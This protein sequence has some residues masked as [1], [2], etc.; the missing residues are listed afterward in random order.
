[1]QPMCWYEIGGRQVS[2]IADPRITDA[3]LLA[4]QA[5]PLLGG[6]MRVEE[7]YFTAFLRRVRLSV[8]LCCGVSRVQG[9]AAHAAPMQ[10]K[11]GLVACMRGCAIIHR[12]PR[13]SH[14]LLAGAAAVG[15]GACESPVGIPEAARAR[16]RTM[17]LARGDGRR[18]DG[19]VPPDGRGGLGEDRLAGPH[20]YRV[21]AGGRQS[22][23]TGTG[24]S[25]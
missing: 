2:P 19:R 15:T 14:G 6:M 22:V 8:C 16:R 10:C 7:L 25:H 18:A 3:H 4:L 5:A 1:V 11:R 12:T 20:C 21:P 13:P 17:R 9:C 23:K 24:R